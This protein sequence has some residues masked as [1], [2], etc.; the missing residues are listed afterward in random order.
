MNSLRRALWLFLSALVL[1]TTA[2]AQTIGRVGTT[3]ASFLKIGVGSRGLAMGGAFVSQAEDASGLYWN[4]AATANVGRVQ[5]LYSH[6]DYILDITYDF[7]GVILPLSGVGTLGAYF[8]FM[9]M[10][11]IERTTVESPD[12]T[13]EKVTASS[14][15]VG[16]S[17][18]AGLTD[19]FSLGASAKYINE[20]IWHSKADGFAFDIGVLYRTF[21]KNIRIGMSI[22]NFGGAMQMDG[23]DMLVQHDI[24]EPIAGNNPNINAHLDTDEFPLPILF[25]VGLSSNITRDLLGME[26]HDWIVAVDAIHPN[27]NKEYLNVGTEVALFDKLISFR[28]GYREV[29]L[30]EREGGL[31][32]GVGVGLNVERGRVA[33]DYANVPIGRLG[34]HHVLTVIL[35]Y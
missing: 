23:R 24:S 21:F 3:A 10:G 13:G 19:R 6:F 9:G 5:A 33:I 26:E 12:G 20:G 1:I 11:E 31:S 34:R 32:F 22:S 8:G 35:S 27:D 17:Y 28:T 25:R 18:A 2:G 15:V 16:V 7:G 29:L 14:F 4:P 30:E